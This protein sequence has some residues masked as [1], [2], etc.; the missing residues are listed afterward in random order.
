MTIM[1]YTDL[2]PGPRSR[3]HVHRSSRGSGRSSAPFPPRGARPPLRL[4]FSIGLGRIFVS[5][6]PASGRP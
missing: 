5:S 4:V 2:H 6:R 3:R 1:T